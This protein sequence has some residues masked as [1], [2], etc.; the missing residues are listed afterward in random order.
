M[1]S[2]N[3]FR[4]AAW[5]DDGRARYLQVVDGMVFGDGR[6][7]GVVRGYFARWRCIAALA[8]DIDR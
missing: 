4:L 5:D 2:W 1:E 8:P 6:S 3:G 7:Q